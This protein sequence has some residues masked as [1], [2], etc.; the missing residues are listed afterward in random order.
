MA[1]SHGSFRETDRSGQVRDGYYAHL[2]L[3]DTAGRWR[4]AYDIALASS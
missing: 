2:W 3:R 4:L 1:A